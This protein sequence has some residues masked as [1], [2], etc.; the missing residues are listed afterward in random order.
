M[1]IQRNTL[2]IGGVYATPN[3]QHRVILGCDST[4]RIV[5]ASKGGNVKNQTYNHTVAC[6]ASTFCRACN[7]CLPSMPKQQFNALIQ[8][9]QAK[10][11]S[12]D[13]CLLN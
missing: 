1:P 12:G 7:T 9:F 6:K 13:A 2:K 5:Y 4:G 8:Q 10:L 3:N 11:V